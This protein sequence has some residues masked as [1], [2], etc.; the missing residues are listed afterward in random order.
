MATNIDVNRR[1]A[2]VLV[3]LLFVL[4]IAGTA[5]VLRGA[6]DKTVPRKSDKES[7]QPQPANDD[8][9]ARLLNS[10]IDSSEF[11][12]AR[13]GVYV[14]S[15]NDGR[16]VY[17]RNADRLFT[18]ASNMK[19][20]TT[21][22]AL[23]LLGSDFR[24]RT[25]V[26]AGK[27]P[28]AN[29]VVEGD[30][31][32]YGR[33]APDLTSRSG[34]DKPASLAQLADELY[35][36]GVRR[37]RGNVI[38][39]ES[40]FRGEPLGD[41]WLWTDVQWYFGAEPS[42]LSIDNNEVAVEIQPSEKSS[43]PPIAKLSRDQGDLKI[44][45][46]FATVKA[47]ERLKV[48]IQRGLSDNNVHVWGEFPEGSRGFGARLSVHRPARLAA[49][50]FSTALKAHGIA[51]DGE[52]RTRDFRVPPEQRFDP[53]RAIEL[54]S[55]SSQTLAEIVKATNKE[56]INLYAELILRTLGRERRALV[57]GSEDQSRERGDDEAGVAVVRLWLE[58]AG[59][60]TKD[61]ALHDGSGLSR[62]DLVT[63]ES[64][65]GLLRAIMKTNSA[66]TFR[67]S[68]PRSGTD[69]TLGGRL[70]RYKD[71][72][73]AKTGALTYDNS[74]SGFLLVPEGE[75]LAFSIMAND[76]TGR[77]SSIRLIDQ[78]VG[79]M[80]DYSSSKTAKSGKK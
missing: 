37:V 46:A 63:P 59:V 74:L 9:L 3:L 22:V 68:L 70:S 53:A 31:V 15:A 45:S 78:I 35:Q 51:V 54:A 48:G 20:Y 28:D 71:Q 79:I 6:K 32:L 67:D 47:G 61:L 24:W 27:Q 38:G 25:S 14:V 23:D 36:R 64:T 43:Q 34:K 2:P 41:G 19:I 1:L 7:A 75:D 40:Y 50:L 10:A 21:A 30:L 80:A 66:A 4:G 12:G 16:V 56:S 76:Q 29:G 33:G 73:I 77:A 5:T 60:N 26:Y 72:V 44:T 49:E 65:V 17:S 8:E 13:W 58:R 11:A 42:A 18:P 57:A 52:P 69:G 39:D 62:L 55:L